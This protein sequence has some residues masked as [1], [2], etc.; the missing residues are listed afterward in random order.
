MLAILF[1]I[2]SAL[3]GVCIVRH[4]M[5]QLLEGAEQILWGI[6]AGW[7]LTSV[8]VYLI[9]RWR[10]ELANKLI[11]AATIAVWIVSAILIVFEFRRPGRASSI[12]VW[13]KKYV[14]LALI[15]ILFTPV[16]FRLLS[17]QIFPHRDGGIYSGS[18][19]NDLAFHAALASSFAYGKNFP[20]A[21]P[22]LPPEP[23][24]YPY[25][26]DFHAALLM[27]G[28]LSMR[29]A[30][31]LVALILGAVTAGLFYSLALRISRSQRA[32]TMATVLFLLNGGF[33][34]SYFFRD[35]WQ[36][37]QSFFAFF[38]SLHTNYA[39]IS[40]RGLHWTNLVADMMVPQRTSLFGLPLALMIFAVFA[41]YWQCWHESVEDKK[42]NAPRSFVLMI[43]AGVLAGLLPLFHTHTYIAVGLIS[44]GLFALR[45]RREWLAFW[46]PAVLL[47]TPQLLSLSTRASGGGIVHVFFGWLGHDQGFFPLYLLRN[48]GLPLLL[49]IPAWWV[50]PRVWQK[51]YLAF[52]LPLAMTFVVVISPSLYDNGKLIYYWH[53]L[54]SILVAMWLVNLAMVHRQRVLASLLAILCVATALIVFRSE[55]NNSARV[56][57]DEDV[58]AAAFARDH[59]G[60]HSLF[61]TAPTLRQP[62]LSF[63]GRAV[64]SSAT[65]WLWSHGYEF[66]ERDADVRR[67]Y[68]GADDA[69]DLLR[70]YQVDYIYFGDAEKSDLRSNPAFFDQNFTV[71]YRSPSIAIYDAHSSL[72]DASPSDRQGAF[73]KPAPRE[74]ASRVDK[75]PFALLVDFPH[76]SFF[77]HRLFKAS[78]GGMPR[79]KDFMSAMSLL[80]RHVFIGAA[81]W[82]EQREINRSALLNDWMNIPAFKQLY[83]DK[84]NADFVDSLLRNSGIE[85]TAGDR[86]LLIKGLD[87]QTQS[88]QAALL[89]IVEDKDFYAH[90]FNTAYVLVHYFGYLRRNPEDAP[91]FDLKGLNFWRDRLD[92]WGDY[93]II[94]RAFIESTEYQ[95]LVPK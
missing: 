36:S 50:A 68:A 20:P 46:T 65:A 74:L 69:L 84:S 58:S 48:L 78:F 17:L 73:N 55:T 67:I 47:A 82:Q 91:D 76:T 31:I 75:D 53:G 8:G 95:A 26:P 39:K 30:F 54:N 44:I 37:N 38:N 19:D 7:T 60:P 59:T 85:W 79:R 81:G 11:I 70:Y 28:G 92:E 16:Y 27:A 71:V 4:V 63:A 18:A 52:L 51:F 61:L 87:S 88:R 34:F 32:A 3:L 43:V 6:V 22:L 64:L 56:F 83:D 15:L 89:G 57:T 23:L 14:G 42:E 35:W 77:V 49:A 80:G 41:F 40:E 90:E 12:F 86:Y 66:R 93:R 9:A 13:Q 5:P 45:P 29:T 62:V 2:G 10:G 25:M 94:S 72:N 1:L 33:G 24:L 21:Y